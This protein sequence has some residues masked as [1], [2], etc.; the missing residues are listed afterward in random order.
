[1]RGMVWKTSDY[2][3][4]SIANTA[5]EKGDGE[6]DIEKESGNSDIRKRCRGEFKADF[7]QTTIMEDQI[8]TKL[9]IQLISATE[10]AQKNFQECLILK[11]NIMKRIYSYKRKN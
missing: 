7:N 8:I 5:D 1:M 3:T 4:F 9:I 6:K 10:Q 11:K 2:D